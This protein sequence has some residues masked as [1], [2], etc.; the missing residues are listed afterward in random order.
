MTRITD[1]L[2]EKP[3]YPPA[4]IPPTTKTEDERKHL[5]YSSPR[6][7][8]T[9]PRRRYGT[10]KPTDQLESKFD[11][12]LKRKRDL[13]TRLSRI[14]TRNLTATDR[15]LFDVLEREISRVEQQISS[16]KLEL[17]KLNVFPV[18]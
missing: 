18:H 2:N 3:I 15:Q 14:P 10:S 11:L 8:S 16:V 5:L 4:Y 12:L 13:E 7:S 9:S 17:R 1:Y 6:K